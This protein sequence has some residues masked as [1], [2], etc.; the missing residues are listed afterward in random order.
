MFKKILIANRGEI[1]LRIIRACN[2]LSINTVLIH[3]Q[4]DADSLPVSL[5][6]ESYCI[7]PAP[8]AQSYLNIPSII[9]VALL[10]GAEAIHPGYGFLAENAHFAE[11][12]REHKIKFIGP[13]PEAI[14][15]MG[16]KATARDTVNKLEV[17]TV[18]G[19]DGLINNLSQAKKLAEEIG[20]PVLIKAT[21]GG[22]GRGMRIV[23]DIKDLETSLNSASQ[24]AQAAF[25]NAGVYIEK[26][27]ANMRH[28]EFQIFADAF[29]NVVHLGERD[30]SI[31][32]RHQKLIEESP[33][34]A[35]NAELREKMGNAAVQIAKS[36]EYEGAGTIE[37]ILDLDTQSFYFMEM[38]TRIQVE[39]PVT[40]IVTGTDLVVEQ[41]NVAANKPLSFKQKDINLN[42]HSIEFRINAEDPLHNF[43]PCPGFIQEYIGPGGVG[44]RLDSHCYEGYVL[45]SFYDSLIGKLIVHGDSRKQAIARAKRALDEY[46]IEGIQT[47]IPFH[48]QVL[49]DENFVTN[50]IT[51]KFLDSFIMKNFD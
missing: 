1:A 23:N 3:S 46:G 47:T 4:A 29:G 32:R 41:I 35:L 31:Q 48:L 45:P 21:A 43:R 17:P 6:D 26:F 18:P 5:A 38:N 34:P 37:F 49:E 44:V 28:I 25:G 22:G 50:K 30:C 40:E 42:G 11:I 14:K 9:N 27:I 24:E 8:A 20:Y 39:H 13:A 12:C 33:S 7:G 16:D 19:S 10:T 51:T 36:I 15:L 2:D